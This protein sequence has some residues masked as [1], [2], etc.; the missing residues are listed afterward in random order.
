M[1]CFLTLLDSHFI[2]KHGIR[3]LSQYY[4]VLPLAIFNLPGLVPSQSY[5]KE[6]RLKKKTQQMLLSFNYFKH[7]PKLKF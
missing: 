3:I 7:K 6:K 5:A 2:H 4:R 1:Y